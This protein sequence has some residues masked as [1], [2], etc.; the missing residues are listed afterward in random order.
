MGVQKLLI[1]LAIYAATGADAEKARCRHKHSSALDTPSILSTPDSTSSTSAIIGFSSTS[2]PIIV[3]TTPSNTTP[4]TESTPAASESSTPSDNISSLYST[5]PSDSS[6]PSSSATPASDATSTPS[7]IISS[8]SAESTSSTIAES[9]SSTPTPTPST[10]ESSTIA[11]TS[12]SSSAAAT[13]TVAA[14]PCA[15]VIQ[16]GGLN[17]GDISPWTASGGAITNGPEARDGSYYYSAAMSVGSVLSVSQTVT[18]LRTNIPYNFRA[19]FRRN[20]G[21]SITI[22]GYCGVTLT[23]NGRDSGFPNSVQQGTPQS[24]WYG[25]STTF[26]A[27][28]GQ[29]VLGVTINC[30]RGPVDLVPI[31]I[32]Q[33]EAWPVSYNAPDLC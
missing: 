26:S 31:G 9:S 16:N 28:T 18:G 2:T 21:G 15:N 8:T 6:T 5:S 24:I 1:A 12:T 30:S 23:I 27:P 13:S 11:S 19:F 25:V 32:D 22:P 3:S 7:I 33:I 14:K 29:A 10:T 20:P 4:S 17:T